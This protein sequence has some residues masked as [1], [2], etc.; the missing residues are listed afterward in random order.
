MS[1]SLRILSRARADIHVIYDWLDQRSTSGAAT[2]YDAL[3]AAVKRIA[4]CPERYPEITEALPRWKRKIHQ[5][6]F[7]TPRGRIYRIIF[8]WTEFEILILRV[9]GPGQRPVRRD[10]L[11]EE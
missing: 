8:E 2:W 9:R 3:T 7:K 1:R 4:D 11:T 10:D 5:S 6:Q